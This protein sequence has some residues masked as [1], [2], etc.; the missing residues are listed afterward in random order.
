MNHN[1]Q[2]R[3]HYLISYRFQLRFALQTLL[4]L[5]FTSI[6]IGWTAYYSVWSAS[7]A[8]LQRLLTS[9][10]IDQAEVLQFRQAIR[11]E[12]GE[13]VVFRLLLLI[14]IAFV[15]T[16]FATHRMAGPIRHIEKALRGHFRGDPFDPI[17]L[18]KTDEFQDLAGL[19]NQLLASERG[20]PHP[21]CSPHPDKA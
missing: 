6:V 15:F 21:G 8:E 1:N 13:R 19:I 16:V 11:A 20:G 3:R 9:E 17:K 2:K 18:R 7:E 10:R 12:A 5:I 14:F 4:L